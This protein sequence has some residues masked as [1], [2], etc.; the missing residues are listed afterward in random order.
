MLCICSLHFWDLSVACAL[1]GVLETFI[2]VIAFPSVSDCL[3]A[4][5]YVW[6]YC[7]AFPVT[8]VRVALASRRPSSLS[9]KAS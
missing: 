1:N 7:E 3:C 2:S 5:R 6:Q 9:C 4:R 8:D